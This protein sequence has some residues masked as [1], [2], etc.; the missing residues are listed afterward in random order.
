MQ[1]EEIIERCQRFER[2]AQE[3]VYQRY[4]PVM[5]GVCRRYMRD[6]MEAENVLSEGFYKA[7]T[8]IGQYRFEG[9]FEGWLRKIMVNE[10]LMHLRRRHNFNI[11]LESS[12]IQPAASGTPYT[13]LAEKSI[14]N[15]LDTLPTGYRTIFNMY[16]IEGYKHREIAKRLGISIHTSKSQ[17]IKAR[18]RLKAMLEDEKTQTG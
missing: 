4:A 12:L 9:S 18:A 8:R 10:A 11:S 6:H 15:L 17:L 1:E 2:R 7:F 5:K 16:V 14:L 13:E 3:L